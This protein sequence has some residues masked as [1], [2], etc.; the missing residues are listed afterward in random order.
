MGAGEGEMFGVIGWFSHVVELCRSI[1]ETTCP[2]WG[3]ASAALVAA[4]L[5]RDRAGY[6]SPAR[7]SSPERQNGRHLFGLIT[8]CVFVN[9]ALRFLCLCL[10]LSDHE[11]ST[12]FEYGR[13]RGRVRSPNLYPQPTRRILF[14]SCNGGRL[15]Q[16]E[17][18]VIANVGNVGITVIDDIVII[19]IYL[20]KVARVD[21]RTTSSMW[22]GRTLLPSAESPLCSQTYVLF[23]FLLF[24]SLSF[25]IDLQN[26]A[27]RWETESGLIDGVAKKTKPDQTHRVPGIESLSGRYSSANYVPHGEG[28]RNLPVKYDSSV[29]RYNISKNTLTTFMNI[30]HLYA[31]SIPGS[32][33]KLSLP[34]ADSSPKGEISYNRGDALRI[35][36]L[37]FFPCAASRVGELFNEPEGERKKE[38]A[39]WL[40]LAFISS[41]SDTCATSSSVS[42]KLKLKLSQHCQSLASPPPTLCISHSHFASASYSVTIISA[43]MGKKNNKKKSSPPNQPTTSTTAPEDNEID[44]DDFFPY[45]TFCDSGS[46]DDAT[47]KADAAR[48]SDRELRWISSI[49]D[50]SAS[51][52]NKNSVQKE[53][54]PVVKEALCKPSTF[55]PPPAPPQP[56]PTDEPTFKK[57]IGGARIAKPIKAGAIPRSIAT[58]STS[59]QLFF[60]KGESRGTTP[61]G[62][63]RNGT[64]PDAADG[65]SRIDVSIK[66]GKKTIEKKNE[67]IPI[68][69]FG[70]FSIVSMVAD[71]EERGYNK[72]GNW[73][74]RTSTSE[75]REGPMLSSTFDLGSD[76][77]SCESFHSEQLRGTGDNKGRSL[78]D[79]L[80]RSNLRS[81]DKSK[82]A[83]ARKERRR[84]K[85][86][87]SRNLVDPEQDDC[88]STDRSR[89]RSN[90]SDKRSPILT[91]S[92]RRRGS[93]TATWADQS[94][95]SDIN[96]HEDGHC[97]FSGPRRRTR[98]GRKK[99]KEKR[100]GSATSGTLSGSFLATLEDARGRKTDNHDDEFSMDQDFSQKFSG[101]PR[102]LSANSSRNGNQDQMSGNAT[103]REVALVGERRVD[104]TQENK[105][106]RKAPPNDHSSPKTPRPLVS[107]PVLDKIALLVEENNPLQ[108]DLGGI[109]LDD[110]RVVELNNS[111]CIQSNP[112]DGES[113]ELDKT[114]EIDTRLLL[115]SSC[116]VPERGRKIKTKGVIQFV[117]CCR[118]RGSGDEWGLFDKKTLEQMINFIE[119]SNANSANGLSAAYKYANMWGKVPIIGLFSKDIETMNGYR[120]RIELYKKD[121]LEFQTF[122]RQT[123][124]RRM[125]LTVMM[126]PNLEGIETQSFCPNLLDRNRG[127]RGG[128]KVLKYKT[129]RS[130]DLD[131][132]GQSMLG[133]RLLQLDADETFL[134]SLQKFPRSHRFGLGVASII[135][136]GGDRAE[137]PEGSTWGS[138]KP[139][140]KPASFRDALIQGSLTRR[141]D[142]LNTSSEMMRSYAEQCGDGTLHDAERTIRGKRNEAGKTK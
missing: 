1:M 44:L 29:V 12:N 10:Y 7:H 116:H 105:R 27:P 19:N 36:S 84:D 100:S 24:C 18:R 81:Q 64:A 135:I 3:Q 5:K 39:S 106:S 37:A 50:E 83:E 52:N 46:D 51:P 4:Y 15:N 33:F 6:S 88:R 111:F 49:S 139:A 138:R 101:T 91:S 142:D 8:S 54:S 104:L 85:Y 21:T 137:E 127:L 28:A 25:T 113:L 120:F 31:W 41:S 112:A 99:K 140:S 132:K 98:R 134:K 107:C 60:K 136:R 130:N 66:E 123:L 92:I 121:G 53:Q 38:E 14:P 76:Y 125:A 109:G 26:A 62:N 48:Q 71:L 90:H 11:R 47:E 124:N 63:T 13:E 114:Q 67:E 122:P 126:W 73:L 82:D 74:N 94:I 70:D 68:A 133:A 102:R 43:V 117:I 55:S 108:G 129:F 23:R 61:N 56:Q 30:F 131:T 35:D 89:S 87:A 93:F 77:D 96:Q 119:N 95:G 128:V 103:S 59:A 22:L 57:P 34:S 40:G 32:N 79:S 65:A 17:T 2:F 118:K 16:T 69:G 80:R 115:P 75:P 78:K 45:V 9:S 20:K 86:D 97:T 58:S 42:F 72:K 110:S 141:S